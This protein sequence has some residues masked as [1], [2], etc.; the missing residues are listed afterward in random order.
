MVF[1]D[2]LTQINISAGIAVGKK[3]DNSALKWDKIK[4]AY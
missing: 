2:C 4:E 3:R 1:D